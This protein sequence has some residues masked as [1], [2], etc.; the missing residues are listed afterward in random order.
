MKITSAIVL[1]IIGLVFG[2][3]GSNGGY[4]RLGIV[5]NLLVLLIAGIIPAIST[6]F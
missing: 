5:G 1:P 2:F 6:I 4:K 3:K